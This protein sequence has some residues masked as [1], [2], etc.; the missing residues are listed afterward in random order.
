M[1]LSSK[2]IKVLFNAIL[3]YRK[4]QMKKL[5]ARAALKRSNRELKDSS[6]IGEAFKIISKLIKKLKKAELGGDIWLNNIWIIIFNNMISDMWKSLTDLL[7]CFVAPS[8]WRSTIRGQWYSCI[9]M[10]NIQTN[11]T[12]ISKNHWKQSWNFQI[13]WFIKN[14]R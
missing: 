2:E 6:D 10:R 13:N 3:A 4:I 12:A 14:H 5:S 1:R 9:H 11:N 7:I 8:R